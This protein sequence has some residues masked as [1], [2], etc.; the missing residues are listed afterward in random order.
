MA[1]PKKYQAMIID[2]ELDSRMRLKN[3]TAA[4]HQFGEV[5]QISKPRE[6]LAKLENMAPG[7]MDVVF[8]ASSNDIQEVGTFVGQAKELPG[9]RDAA[10]LLV[11]KGHSQ[12]KSIIA[13]S[14]IAG[15]DGFLFEPYSVD[16]LVEITELSSKI[17]TQRGQEREKMAVTMTLNDIIPQIDY[18]ALLLTCMMDATSALSKLKKQGAIFQNLPPESLDNFCNV[19]RQ[20]FGSVTKP[21]VQGDSKSRALMKRMADK[22]KA[23]IEEKENNRE[24]AKDQK[25]GAQRVIVKR[26]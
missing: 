10:Y 19:A 2:S 7:E 24:E 4:V 22:M 20:I 18:A 6:A 11:L 5:R 21:R 9:G 13:K 12:D 14:V 1:V 25:V 26:G 17:R 8:L 15:A 3:A 23:E 16:R